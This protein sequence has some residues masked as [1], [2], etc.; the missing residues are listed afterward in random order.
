MSN[1]HSQDLKYLVDALRAYIGSEEDPNIGWIGSGA[2]H[3]DLFKCETC[4]QE[5]LDCSQIEH[6]KY[7]R[8]KALIDAFR[9]FGWP[10]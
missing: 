1:N 4:Y 9:K 8:A 5:H 7:C 10:E 6:T 3:K 2:S